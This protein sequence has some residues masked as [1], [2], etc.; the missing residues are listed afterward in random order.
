MPENLVVSC[1]FFICFRLNSPYAFEN[2]EILSNFPFVL[3]AQGKFMTQT[4]NMNWNEPTKNNEYFHF[5]QFSVLLFFFCLVPLL[6]F[7]CLRLLCIHFSLYISSYVRHTAQ[8]TKIFSLSFVFTFFLFRSIFSG[9]MQI[10]F[11]FSFSFANSFD[12]HKS[13]SFEWLITTFTS[14]LHSHRFTFGALVCWLFS[15]AFNGKP[16]TEHCGIR[17][18]KKNTNRMFLLAFGALEMEFIFGA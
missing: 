9:L 18:L 5:I 12:E 6:G 8:E 7:Q 17:N 10:Q 3:G 11:A 15:F 13:C 1:S 16:T 2:T 14:I 4:K